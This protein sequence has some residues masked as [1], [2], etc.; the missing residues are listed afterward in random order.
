VGVGVDLRLQVRNIDLEPT[1]TMFRRRETG[2]LMR[3][4]IPLDRRVAIREVRHEGL[5]FLVLRRFF[6]SDH[7]H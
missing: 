2:V 4:G 1:T 6:G 3:V 5:Q 7:L